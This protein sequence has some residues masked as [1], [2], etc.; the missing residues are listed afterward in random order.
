MIAQSIRKLDAVKDLTQEHICKS[1]NPIPLSLQI[2]LRSSISDFAL[3]RSWRQVMDQ[4]AK[5]GLEFRDHL[6]ERVTNMAARA[7]R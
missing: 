1:Y 6:L 4:D 3:D 5:L 7:P 2:T